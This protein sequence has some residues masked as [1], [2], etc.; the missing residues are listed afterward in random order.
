MKMHK[1]E[2][3]K[4]LKRFALEISEVGATDDMIKVIEAQMSRAPNTP[5]ASSEEVTDRFV[6]RHAG[7]LIEA[8]CTVELRVKK[9][10]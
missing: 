1:E 4:L 9:C 7:Y 10:K 3:S 2:Y 5:S 6:Y 8:V